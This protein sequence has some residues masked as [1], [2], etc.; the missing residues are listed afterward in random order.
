MAA[1]TSILSAVALA[2]SA[3]GTVVGVVGATQQ[4]SAQK[5]AEELRKQ[6]MNLDATRQRRDILRQSIIARSQALSTATAQGAASGSGLAG[7]YG[8]VEG[9]FARGT[10]AVNQNQEIGGKIFDA[11]AS[12]DAAG[13]LAS[14]GAGL[15]SLGG[16]TLQNMP[17]IKTLFN[18]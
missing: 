2:A 16:A 11:N 14:A 12:A 3:V 5:K 6:Q 7:A 18:G 4:A 17:T 10:Q 13:G 8:Q 9:Q 1:I 15:A